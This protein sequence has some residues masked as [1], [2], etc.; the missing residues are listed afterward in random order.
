VCGG[1]LG[2]GS[3]PRQFI[4]VPLDL[5]DGE[6][7]GKADIAIPVAHEMTLLPYVLAS[8]RYAISS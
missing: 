3:D 2:G 8:V 7:C 6:Q 4:R 5:G 1:L